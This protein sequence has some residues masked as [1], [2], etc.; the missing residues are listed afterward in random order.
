MDSMYG[1][2]NCGE[3]TIIVK[4]YLLYFSTICNFR[5]LATWDM[6]TDLKKR[7]KV[8]KAAL[9]LM[10]KV[11]LTDPTTHR[12]SCCNILVAVS[13]AISFVRLENTERKAVQ[14]K[15]MAE[16]SNALAHLR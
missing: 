15:L 5:I 3:K 14:V 2:V 1:H 13:V 12:C 10:V 6:Q 7:T 16:R 4:V 9:S 8:M 11:M